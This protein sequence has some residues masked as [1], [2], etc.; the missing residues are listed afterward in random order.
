[1]SDDEAPDPMF[2]HPEDWPVDLRIAGVV[3]L[4]LGAVVVAAFFFVR[5][6]G[7]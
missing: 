1:M 5:L 4:W 3:L 7:R 6:I 2:T